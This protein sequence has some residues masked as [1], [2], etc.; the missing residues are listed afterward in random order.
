MSVSKFI[1]IKIV[2]YTIKGSYEMDSE[3]KVVVVSMIFNP[4]QVYTL[5]PVC[6]K[7]ET[8]VVVLMEKVI[9]YMINLTKGILFF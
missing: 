8:Q 4:R 1:Y 5:D 7:V 9:R 6:R 3:R 2:V